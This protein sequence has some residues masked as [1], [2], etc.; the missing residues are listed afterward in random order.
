MSGKNA[1]VEVALC[2]GTHESS[3]NLVVAVSC[4]RGRYRHIISSHLGLI[5]CLNLIKNKVTMHMQTS[6]VEGC[7]CTRIILPH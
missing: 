2:A 7:H 5:C 6:V 4:E 3:K 1:A